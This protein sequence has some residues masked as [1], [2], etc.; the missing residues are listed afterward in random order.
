MC[1]P[2]P[3]SCGTP[4]RSVLTAVFGQL[5][6]EAALRLT[7]G[8]RQ[9]STA[10][11]EQAEH[12]NRSGNARLAVRLLNEASAAQAHRVARGSSAD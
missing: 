2:E 3:W 7:I 10:V 8:A 6:D 4:P 12:E 1:A 9:K 11:I 5:A